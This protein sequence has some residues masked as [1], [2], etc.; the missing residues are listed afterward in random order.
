MA[1]AG[2]HTSIR[3]VFNESAPKDSFSLRNEGHCVAKP[4]QLMVNLAPSR[5]RLIFDPTGSGA[6]VEVFQPFQITRGRNLVSTVQPVS[7]G[8]N[9][10]ILNFNRLPP[11]ARFAFTI[12]VDATLERSETGPT[13]I[14]GVEIEGGS[15]IVRVR[16]S[17]IVLRS[18]FTV[19]AA[20]TRRL[21]ET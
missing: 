7:D 9:Q 12:H 15:I 16:D 8:D 2:E 5:G 18:D 11:K 4:V 1:A 19:D 20:A 6:G 13:R 14:S 17:A 10:L 21:I 3:L